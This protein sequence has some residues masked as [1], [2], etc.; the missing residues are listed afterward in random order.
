MLQRSRCRHIRQVGDDRVDRRGYCFEKVAVADK[1][2][3]FQS[4]TPDVLASERDGA[5]AGVCRPYFDAGTGARDRY[6]D[7]STPRPDIGNAAAATGKSCAGLVDHP[8]ACRARCHHASGRAQQCQTFESHQPD[9]ASLSR[10]PSVRTSNLRGDL[11]PAS[12]NRSHHSTNRPGG[13]PPRARPDTRASQS[14][15]RRASDPPGHRD[16][17]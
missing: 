12:W 17:S 3:V 5:T 7:C 10:R 9:A 1:D 15:Q 6:R 13:A 16:L 4:M 8:L 14:V 2:S 11:S